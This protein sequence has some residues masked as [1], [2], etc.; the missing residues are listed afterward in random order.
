MAAKDKEMADAVLEWQRHCIALENQ[1]NELSSELERVSKAL[2]KARSDDPDFEG[3][4]EGK[5]TV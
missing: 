4:P 3:S 2:V 1:N 5:V